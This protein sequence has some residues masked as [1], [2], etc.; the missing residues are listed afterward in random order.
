M[1][2]NIKR[3]AYYYKNHKL[4]F[5]F[6]M[7][8]SL[9]VAV[10][11]IGYPIITRN[12]L[13][14]WIPNKNLRY[15]IFGGVFLLIIYLIRTLFRYYICYYGHK[16]GA[17]M[18][19]EMRKDLFTKLEKLPYMFFD[20]HESGELMSRLTND[21]EDISELAHHGPENI[22]IAGFTL[23]G[24]LIYLLTI[25]WVLG[26]IIFAVAPLC[27]TLTIKLRTKSRKAFKESKQAIG[28]VNAQVGSSITGIRVTKAFTNNKKE[29]EMFDKK[30]KE[31]VK[32]RTSIFKYMGAFIS[33]NQLVQDIF[34]VVIL[35]AGGIFI[36]YSK[37]SFGDYSAFIVSVSLF[38]SPLNQILNF[39]EQFQSGS[40]GFNRFVEIMDEEEEKDKEDA[41]D[42]ND[43]KGKIE[44]N[45]VS[46]GYNEKNK[47]VLNNVS[48]E[49]KKGEKIA[50][51]GPSGGGKT[52]I[53]HL[54]P[55]FY[56]LSNGDILIDNKSIND[57]KMESLRKNIGIVQQDVFLFNG[58]I[59]ENILYGKLDATDEELKDAC[60]KANIT[61]FINSLD[62]GWDTLVGERGVK[63][64]GGQKQRLSIARVFL[65]N[66]QILIL[67]EA[68]SALDN[69]TEMLIQESL[70]ELTKGR[71]TIIVAHRL[72]T[73]KHADE[74]IVITGGEI[75]EK[76]THEEL[77]KQ[78]GIYEKLYNLQFRDENEENKV[79]IPLM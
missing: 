75:K 49:I 55:R 70:D 65:K 66:P 45:D 27:F 5:F 36:Y 38:I 74:I 77:I 39:T 71:T 79:N 60:D 40:A 34:N 64:S 35:V 28:K 24:S 43:V 51:V 61:E 1:M 14:D 44:F 18:Q 9:L 20:N 78:N 31:F 12:M 42:L 56:T 46:F 17:E 54:I 26:L 32:I 19:G 13:N 37:I 69:T 63:L 52:T 72:S 22:F 53:C 48:F 67:D 11:G 6:D 47:E 7:L 29:Q 8:C 73:I 23:I 25:N 33:V 3:F 76:G 57:I 16:M 2:K 21:L 15:V 30:N 4:V 59:K 62:D 58:T 68:T 10:I 41:I 50:L